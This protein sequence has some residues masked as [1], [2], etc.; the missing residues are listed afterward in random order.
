[1]S[2]ACYLGTPEN[3]SAKTKKM[4]FSNNG[5]TVK[6]K[7]GYVSSDN[8]ARL[9]WT[10][11]MKA[12]GLD[13][14]KALDDMPTVI[15]HVTD[16]VFVYMKSGD[17][18]YTIGHI[19]FD[20]GTVT[21]LKTNIYGYPYKIGDTSVVDVQYSKNSK[22]NIIGCY[23][24]LHTYIAETNTIT[25]T[26]ISDNVSAIGNTY[27]SSSYSIRNLT[28]IYSINGDL[29][30]DFIASSGNYYS[31]AFVIGLDKNNIIVGKGKLDWN[32][33]QPRSNQYMVSQTYDK[34]A[35][36][37]TICDGS[38]SADYSLYV[39]YCDISSA[40]PNSLNSISSSSVSNSNSRVYFPYGV[41]W[42]DPTHIIVGYRRE[43]LGKDDSPYNYIDS[44]NTETR[45]WVRNGVG[46]SDDYVHAVDCDNGNI[47]YASS[48]NK[49]GLCII[50]E[51]GKITL[52]TT[53]C[54]DDETIASISLDNEDSSANTVW[55][56]KLTDSKYVLFMK[57][58][59]A[60]INLKY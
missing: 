1:M 49:I 23:Y 19:D 24:T 26:D 17:S 21:D 42:S 60:I 52:D 5:S 54:V 16:D 55:S 2:K 33:S 47:L 43:T 7:K 59:W 39:R 57:S 56:H 50:D 8:K 40:I 45:E 11:S 22:G 20:T 58:H 27:Y 12:T 37:I 10:S 31:N 53:N 29:V 38:S 15:C 4:Y 6:V 44:I 48:K 3:V 32:L 28:H 34:F 46:T 25:N 30:I 13:F 14:V 9:F 35:A 36:Q 18:T 41:G 51:S